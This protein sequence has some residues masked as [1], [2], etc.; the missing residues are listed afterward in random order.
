MNITI[1][2][3]KDT[4]SYYC[5]RFVLES[6][7]KFSVAK[8]LAVKTNVLWFDTFPTHRLMTSAEALGSEVF[9]S[10]RILLTFQEL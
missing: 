5:R 8:N 2:T 1:K 10:W 6:M 4:I 7:W 9:L 3:S